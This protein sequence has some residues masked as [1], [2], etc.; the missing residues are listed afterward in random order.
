MAGIKVYGLKELQWRLKKGKDL[1]DVKRAVKKHGAA[2]QREM[3][4]KAD[5]R[6]HM[7]Y[8]K[9][10]GLTF[11]APTGETKKSIGLEIEGGGF[12]ASVGPTTEYSEYLEYGTRLMNAQPF[13]GPALEAQEDKF[14]AELKELM[15]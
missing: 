6:G 13:I 1:D 5:F 15:R 2:L 3:Q 7:E 9:G 8:V 4:R 12:V 11:V 14:I 10:K